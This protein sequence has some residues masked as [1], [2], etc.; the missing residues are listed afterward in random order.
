MQII[1][2]VD[3]IN[4]VFDSVEMYCFD[5]ST[6][7]AADSSEL[8]LM[9]WRRTFR[10]KQSNFESK[11]FKLKNRYRKNSRKTSSL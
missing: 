6:N 3:Q 2:L 7:A 4:N 5:S 10:S 1:S 11:L 8:S 9:L